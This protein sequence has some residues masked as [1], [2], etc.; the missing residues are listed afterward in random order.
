MKKLTAFIALILVF[1][2]LAGCGGTSSTDAKKEN[3]D[4]ESYDD[5][6]EIEI[7][8]W[9]DEN[10][11]GGDKQS[12]LVAKRKQ[13]IE[14]KYNVKFKY[15]IVPADDIPARFVT[16]VMSGGGTFGDLV[17]MRHYWAFPKFV[18][19]ENPYLLDISKYVDLENMGFREQDLEIA[20][21]N[22][23]IY[24]IP[25]GDL[26]QAANIGYLMY[27]NKK[28][29]GDSMSQ[30]YDMYR[31]K[32]W[33]WDAVFDLA[34]KH[35][36]TAADGSV[37]VYGMSLLND[38]ATVEVMVS[39]FGGTYMQYVNGEAKS[40]V[41]SPNVTNA[42]DLARKAV[43]TDKISP[44]KTEGE[45]AAFR[46]GKY[47]MYLG[48]YYEANEFKAQ[49]EDDFGIM[50]VP[51]GGD[52]T[53]YV[54]FIRER[55]FKVA[56]ANT[57]KTRMEKIL[58]IYSEYSAPFENQDELL[59]SEL[60]AY[61]CDEESVEVLR[62]INKNYVVPEYYNFNTEYWNLVVVEGVQKALNGSITAATAMDKVNDA[63][64]KAISD[65]L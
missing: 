56:A 64:Q 25:A 14:K 16:D 7:I 27:I 33:T 46:T 35:T 29:F 40:T 38:Y 20:S 10:P 54:N 59:T 49:M 15:T 41:T 62:E 19:G 6:G 32:T 31:N 8:S 24:G 55:H 23:S 63:W 57:D 12:D 2:M 1:A 42:I 9:W 17:N 34:K 60:E 39:S 45:P 26:A 5:I 51:L 52:Q 37:S 61:S 18:S 22:G 13:D 48:S 44:A 43:F 30:I 36:K 3:A 65:Q 50:P 53:E 28:Y 11:I 47:A 4:T 21:H 58:K